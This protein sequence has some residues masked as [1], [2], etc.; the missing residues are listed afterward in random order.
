M[1]GGPVKELKERRLGRSQLEASMKMEKNRLK[2]IRM[3]AERRFAEEQNTVFEMELREARHQQLLKL[4]VS[5]TNQI[6]NVESEI[7]ER[8]SAAS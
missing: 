5:E 7:C 2:A 6:N 4:F 8:Q 3:E 1:N